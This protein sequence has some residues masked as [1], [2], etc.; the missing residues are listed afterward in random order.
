M[1]RTMIL[2]LL[3]QLDLNE[4]VAEKIR[5]DLKS[6][7]K[8]LDSIKGNETMT[9]TEFLNMLGISGSQYIKPYKILFHTPL[10]F[11]N[12]PLLK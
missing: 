2:E 8:L 5:K 4:N 12:V 1:P 6:I 3:N 10:Y 9:F 11:R 7:C